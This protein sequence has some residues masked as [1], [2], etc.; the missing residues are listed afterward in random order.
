MSKSSLALLGASLLSLV[1]GFAAPA[2]PQV[3]DRGELSGT[4]HDETGASLP[5]V[6][7]TIT[8]VETGLT[9]VVTTDGTGRYRA[10]LLP[11]GAYTIRAELPSFATVTRE[12][13]VV[14]VGSAP[15]IDLTLP[16]ATVTE[17]VTV[18]AASPV[19]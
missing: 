10:P 18:T 6:T 7:I 19:V 15:V 8:H 2:F 14:T 16:L 12:G 11:V 3:L 1:A 4:V 5:G 13:V 9:R 17:A